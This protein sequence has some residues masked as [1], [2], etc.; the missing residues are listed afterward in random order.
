[1][2]KIDGI[3]KLLALE[4]IRTLAMRYAHYR[5]GLHLDKLASLFAEDGVCEFGDKFGGRIVG[6]PAIRRHFEGSKS[7]G[8]GVP[9]GTL[10]AIST[11][12]IEFFDRDRAEGRCYLID[13]ITTNA[14]PLAYLIVYDDDYRRIGGEWKFQRR[15]IEAMWP[16]RDIRARL[17]GGS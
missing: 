17:L 8:G 6:R 14:D 11:H 3:E 5:D 7:I 16:H 10:H 15:R 12:W 13:F 4:E 2:E 9:F 1:M